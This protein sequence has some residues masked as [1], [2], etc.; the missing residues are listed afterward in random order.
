MLRSVTK[1]PSIAWFCLSF[2]SVSFNITQATFKSVGPFPSLFDR[3][4]FEF[5]E[6]APE[7]ASSL[8]GILF[9]AMGIYKGCCELHAVFAAEKRLAQVKSLA[10]S[11]QGNAVPSN[12]SQP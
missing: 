12:I 7:N 4:R 5:V 2:I 6:N 9:F 1:I 11:E 10:A 3:L 8:L